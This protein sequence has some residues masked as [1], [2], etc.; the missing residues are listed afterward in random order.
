VIAG[1]LAGIATAVAVLA[2]AVLLLPEPS[3]TVDA[4]PSPTAVATATPGPSTSVAA[5]SL[6]SASTSP[7]VEAS[8][9]TTAFHVGEKAPDL[10]V[11]QLGGGTVSLAALAG[12]PVW[13]NFMQTT[14]PP[15]VDECPVMSGFAA[16]YA[17]TG[18]VV[19]A[20]DVRE[21]EGAIA[22]FVQSVNASFPVGLDAT[23][24]AATAW[25]A[26]ALPV[27]FWIDR[28]GIIRAGALGGIGPDAM[29][30]NLQVILPD[31]T[32]TP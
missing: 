10:T 30:T 13:V 20:I 2:G 14:C 17:S 25:D 12:H 15:C 18:L 6:P 16:R 32:V 19:V 4:S 7:S 24:S 8:I 5:S 31:V 26:V 29:A 3:G 11:P 27:H 21:D 1:L 28:D 22:S 9:G 23:G